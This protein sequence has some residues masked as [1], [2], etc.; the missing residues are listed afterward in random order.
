MSGIGILKLNLKSRD[1]FT[2]TPEFLGINNIRKI[3]ISN[4]DEA[5]LFIY[6][7]TGAK[8]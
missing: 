5:C 6:C 3:C 2:I 8:T 7:N 1:F 4:L